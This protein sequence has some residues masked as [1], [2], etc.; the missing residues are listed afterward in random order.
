MSGGAEAASQATAF[1]E[2]VMRSTKARAAT[3]SRAEADDRRAN[4]VDATKQSGETTEDGEAAPAMT[5]E[6]DSE[7]E[8]SARTA[9]KTGSLA[10]REEG[11]T[12]K[13][14]PGGGAPTG[15]R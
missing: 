12:R 4:K 15:G 14:A 13:G 10:S 6:S 2:E 3:T 8:A 9:K 5:G 11:Q 1:L 7:S